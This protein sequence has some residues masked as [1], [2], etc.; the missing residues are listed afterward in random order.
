MSTLALKL[1]AASRRF[2]R[3][4]ADDYDVMADGVV[5][6]HVFL[7]PTAPKHRPWMWASNE[8]MGRPPAFGY[9]TTRE[10]AVRALARASGA[11]GAKR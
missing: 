2:W 10:E 9:E 1:V 8:H 7:S 6:G 4:W 5:V 3:W 11:N